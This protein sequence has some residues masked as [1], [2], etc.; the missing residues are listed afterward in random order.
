[1]SS[2]SH[3]ILNMAESATIAMSQKCREL[4]AEGL[5]IVNLS[6]GE[7]DFNTPDHIKKAAIEALDKNMTHYPPVAGYPELRKAVCERL[8]RDLGLD[9]DMSQVCISAGGKHTLANVIMSVLDPGDEVVI[10]APYWVTY[11]ELVK[12]AEAKVVT[13]ECG[14]EQDFKITAEQLEKAITPKTKMLMIN[15]PS[16]PTGAMYTREELESLAEVLKRHEGIVV[17]ADEIYDMIT[18]GQPH[19]SMA[20][21][22]GMKDRTII[23]NGMSKG[24]AMTGWRVGYMAAPVEIA[25]ACIKLQG[26]FTSGVNT[27][28]EAASIAALRESDEPSRKMTEEFHRR[29]DMMLELLRQ[30]PG[31]KLQTPPGAFYLFPDVSSYFGKSYEG[32]KIENSAD[33]VYYLLTVGHVATVAS[34]AF[35]IEGH[36]RLSY[37]AS[38]EKLRKAAERIK[39]A[40]A[41]LK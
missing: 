17:L 32:K 21:I 12:L 39:K 36:I 9:Y 40:L 4:Q 20:Q 13:V 6:I 3:R 14:I 5:D 22:D 29:R 41:D 31:I 23:C 2:I 1:M 19:C 18:Y 30:I 37:A 28:A 34:S 8:K 11:S 38:E 27:I 33:M 15:S 26:Q 25:K 10:P 16:N 7:P 35:G 24:Y